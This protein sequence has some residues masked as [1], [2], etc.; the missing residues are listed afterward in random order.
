LN[1]HAT[2]LSR[3]VMGHVVVDHEE[4]RRTFPEGPGRLELMMI[5]EVQHGRIARAWTIAGPKTLDGD[6]ANRTP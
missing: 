5:Y 1:L 3:T 4:V 2:L 6:G